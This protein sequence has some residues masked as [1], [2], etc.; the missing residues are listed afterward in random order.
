MKVDGQGINERNHF[1]KI[2]KFKCFKEDEI[3]RPGLSGWKRGG[4]KNWDK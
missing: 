2:K 1:C 4:R 3:R